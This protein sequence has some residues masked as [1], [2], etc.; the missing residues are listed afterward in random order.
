M[1][2]QL[3]RTR[4]QILRGFR[5][6]Q[7]SLSGIMPSTAAIAGPQVAAGRGLWASIA[8]SVGKLPGSASRF[9]N[10]MSKVS[11]LRFPTLL[12]L[13]NIFVGSAV[14]GAVAWPVKMAADIEVAAAQLGVFVGG[15][16]VARKM[17]ME[18]QEFSSVSMVPFESLSR[19]A[20]LLVRYGQSASD[21]TK[22]T[23]ALAVLAAGDAEEFEKL[24]LAFAQ[25]G[26]AGRLQG[27]E[28][29][30]FKNTAFNPLREI[31]ERTGETMDEVKTRMEA[32][33]ISFAEV[34]SALQATVGPA[35]RFNGLLEAISN[36]L[37]GQV[38]KAFAGFKLAVLPIGEELLAP[39]TRFFRAIS[40]A[41]PAFAQFVKAN[42]GVA[43]IILGTMVAVAIGAVVFTGLGLAATVAS[44]AAAGI[45]TAFGVLLASIMALLSPA[46]LLAAA[47][48]G[49][50][51]W[52]FAT[53]EAGR[54][55][56][57]DLAGYFTQLWKVAVNTFDGI[58]DALKA[59]NIEL[60]AQILWAG[61][62]VAWLKGTQALRETWITFKSAFL[63]T[64]LE[65]IDVAMEAW[66]RFASH[67]Q[68]L[69]LNM[70]R[71]I[72]SSVIDIGAFLMKIGLSK[73]DKASVDT[74]ANFLQNANTLKSGA[75]IAAAESEKKKALDDLAAAKKQ[76]LEQ[77]AQNETT[78]LK[79]ARERLA[80]AEKQ[81]AALQK[82]A[83]DEA[84]LPVPAKEWFGGS[85]FQA[86]VLGG[87]SKAR[88]A[89]NPLAFLDTRMAAQAAGMNSDSVLRE[90]LDI[91]RRIERNTRRRGGGGLPVV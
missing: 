73:E 14:A 53:T 21:A 67:V 60:A 18:L 39:I 70:Q 88:E 54:H 52:F 11:S 12:S 4:A 44:V 55:A 58:A 84:A 36:T 75:A 7:T 61:L 82:T 32:G 74:L 15:V 5:Q 38:R 81:L 9:H 72:V 76:A 13:R 66:T 87:L 48:A 64:T 20:A 19:T 71:R 10:L 85:K 50:V 34:A 1:H 77:N 28:M 46:G 40:G 37:M 91:Q 89:T 45:A 62:Q 63:A 6:L 30:Q 43:K 25:V 24:A 69:Y 23:E 56:F 51:Y 57:T 16:D 65:V 8:A 2:Q 78:E 83:A 80:E 27:E 49:L 31:A 86:D 22:N 33:T 42:A 17:L 29:R 68:E 90:Q 3:K 47:I 41:M 79:T 26:N 35:G 59:G